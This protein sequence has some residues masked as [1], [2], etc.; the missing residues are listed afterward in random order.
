MSKKKVYWPIIL[1]FLFAIFLDF[2][3]YAKEININSLDVN[4]KLLEDGSLYIEEV[5]DFKMSGDFNGVYREINTKYSGGV[6]DIKVTELTA[7]GEREFNKV[8][9]AKNGQDGVYQILKSGDI[10]NLKIYSPAKDTNKKFKIYYKLKNVAVKYNDIGELR[11]RFW[12]DQSENVIDRFNINLTIGKLADRSKLQVFA[13]GPID[14]MEA[15]ILDSNVFNI[16][17]EKVKAKTPIEGRFLFPKDSIPLSTNIVGENALNR[18][19]EEESVNQRAIEDE[20]NRKKYIRSIGNII[21]SAAFVLNLILGVYIL[22]IKR[23]KVEDDYN[24]FPDDCTPAIASKLYKNVINER[25]VIATI[26]DLVRKK[27][28][29]IKDMGYDNYAIIKNRNIDDNLL[30]HEKFAIR[31]FIDHIGNGVKVELED[32]ENYSKKHRNKFF[33]YFYKWKVMVKHE[34]GKKDYYDKNA[35]KLAKVFVSIFVTEIAVM[36]IFLVYGSLV[37]IIGL[38]TALFSTI[39]SF[40]LW[41]KKSVYG[42]NQIRKWKVFKKYLEDDRF[43]KDQNLSNIETIDKYLVYAVSLGVND[44]IFEKLNIKFKDK[45]VGE[46]NYCDSCLYWYFWL[47]MDDEHN[48]IQDSLYNPSSSGSSDGGGYSSG[49]SGGC[50]GG[51]DAGG[52]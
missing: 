13:R 36:V 46:E 47:D 11:Y 15:L 14:T 33:D 24:T 44:R 31:W 34:F 16:K 2:K 21:G 50:A 26:L 8:E 5:I 12:G 25:D 17:G 23:T 20:K 42:E 1:I 9:D 52:F 40:S 35:A 49:D 28:L 10:Y 45:G 18:I 43:I 48:I 7:S 6:Q 3:V 41:G 29:S 30:S 37:S 39:F 4:S 27:Y 38:I 19:L 22:K 32:I 51:G